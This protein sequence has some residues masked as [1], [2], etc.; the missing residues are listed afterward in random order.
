[1][2][3][4]AAIDRAEYFPARCATSPDDREKKN[5]SDSGSQWFESLTESCAWEKLQT[6]QYRKLLCECFLIKPRTYALRTVNLIKKTPSNGF[7]LPVSDA[8]A[9]VRGRF[10]AG[11]W[12]LSGGAT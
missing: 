7:F 3:F 8:T 12:D 6:V 1:M 5:H 9:S 2:C 10:G 4:S 11:P